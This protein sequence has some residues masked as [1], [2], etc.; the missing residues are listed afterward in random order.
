MSVVAL[1][2]LALATWRITSIVQGE[3]GPWAICERIRERMGIE[4]DEDGHPISYPDTE[5]GRLTS[6]PLCGS[7]WVGA[8][9][10][11]VHL[12]WPLALEVV[13]LPF[14]LSALAILIG[15]VS[16]RIDQEGG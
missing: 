11:G 2:I 4:H 15:I 3:R 7:V 16:Q 12:A 5:L 10:A 8:G 14:A 6:C 9:L 1:T 13:C